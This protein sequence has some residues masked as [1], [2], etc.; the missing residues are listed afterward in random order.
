MIDF[1]KSKFSDKALDFLQNSDA[2]L[3]ILHGSVRSSKT[4]NCSIRWI[5]YCLTGPPG[6]LM[7]VG[8][9]VATLQ[10]NVLND[11]QDILGVKNFKWVNRQQ[12]ELYIL[13]RRV[14]AVGA[15]SEEAEARIRGVTLAGAL[16]DEANL[17]PRSFFAQLMARLSVPGAQCFCN[18]NPDSPFHWFYTDYITNDAITNKKVWHFLLDDNPNLDPEYITSLKQ[19]YTGMFY[20]RFILGEWCVAEGAIY[21]MFDKDTHVVNKIPEIPKFGEILIGCDYG[22]STVMSWSMFYRTPEGVYYKI[23]E[24]FYDA[25]KEKKQK[26]DQEFFEDFKRW[27]SKWSYLKLLVYVDPSASSWITLLQR[28]AAHFEVVKADNDVINGIRVVGSKLSSK[29]L[30]F[31]ESCKNTIQEYPNYMWDPQKQSSGVDK[32]IKI[33]DHAVD[34]DRYVIYTRETHGLSGVYNVRA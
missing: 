17:Y 18:C 16:C 24:Y 6:D 21:D 27:A 20:R 33:D 4:V 11:L 34:S 19:M 3:N 28:D 30:F 12:G 8:K 25:R 26:T 14:H 13:G 10:R 32:P 9:T 1:S 15:S 7:M 23:S 31:H 29:Q 5:E 22:T 2:R